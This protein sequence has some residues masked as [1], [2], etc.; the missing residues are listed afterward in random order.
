MALAGL[1]GDE[2]K[3]SDTHVSM[4]ADSLLGLAEEPPAPS[5]QGTQYSPAEC[6]INFVTVVLSNFWW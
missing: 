6:S 5:A 2:H 1:S 3:G 4:G